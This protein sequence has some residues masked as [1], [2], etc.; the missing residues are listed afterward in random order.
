MH[1]VYVRISGFHTIADMER[2]FTIICDGMA[3]ASATLDDTHARTFRLAFDVATT[4]NQSAPIELKFVH[5]V[6]MVLDSV[7]HL[8]AVVIL[9]DDRVHFFQTR[10]MHGM[11]PI[12]K[13]TIECRSSNTIES[14]TLCISKCAINGP[15]DIVSLLRNCT[16]LVHIFVEMRQNQVDIQ[17]TTPGKMILLVIETILS[18]QW[19]N[20]GKI[21]HG[22]IIR[23]LPNIVAPTNLVTEYTFG[24][25]PFDHNGIQI[26]NVIIW[27]G[28]RMIS[29]ESIQ[30]QTRNHMQIDRFDTRTYTYDT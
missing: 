30:Q 18:I 19:T 3:H 23:I 10:G 20:K 2:M 28:E 15:I 26:K 6:Q 24:W 9:W 29:S 7:R 17:S 12:W 4:H 13:K 11:Q 22:A 25:R 16:H 8:Y 27:P 14:L 1:G 5:R 21:N